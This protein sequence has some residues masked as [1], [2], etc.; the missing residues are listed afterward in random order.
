MIPVSTG[1]NTFLKKKSSVI[2]NKQIEQGLDYVFLL[3]SAV[4]C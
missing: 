1:I 3:G 4:E 2:T